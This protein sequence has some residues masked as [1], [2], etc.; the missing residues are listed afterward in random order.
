MSAQ[1]IVRPT[2]PLFIAKTSIESQ[3]SSGYSGTHSAVNEFVDNSIEAGATEVRV[4]YVPQREGR[5]LESHDIIVLDNGKGMDPEL[6]WQALAFGGGNRFD[7]R[8]IGRFGYGLPNAAISQGLHLDVY[9]W[10]SPNEVYKAELDVDRIKHGE[11]DGIQYPELEDVPDSIRRLLAR[12]IGTYPKGE[13][14]EEN[15]LLSGDW[16]DH[17]TLVVVTKCDRLSYKQT[18]PFV[19]HS[20]ELGRIYRYKLLNGVRIYVNNRLIDP[21]DPLYLNPSARHSGAAAW[22]D[23]IKVEIPLLDPTLEDEEGKKNLPTLPVVARFSLLPEAWMKDDMKVNRNQRHLFY[24]H[25]ISVLRADREMEMTLTKIIGLKE[26]DSDAWWGGEIHVPPGLD[27][28]FGISNN[29]QGIHPKAYVK[30]YLSRAL[31]PAISRLRQTVEQRRKEQREARQGGEPTFTERRAAEAE[32]LLGAAYTIPSDPQYQEQVEKS[33]RDF[34]K[35]HCRTGE[36]PEV[37]YERIKRST[38]L[39][40]FEHSPEGPFYRVDNFGRHVVTY[41]NT[42]HKFYDK[43]WLPLGNLVPAGTADNGGVGEGDPLD[44]DAGAANPQAA[45]AMLL[46]TIGRVEL[47]FRDRGE[48]AEELF[49]T[50]RSDW[51][52]ALRTFLN[53]LN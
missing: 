27:E 18:R 1:E 11:L 44:G 4:Y 31:K 6:L 9:T 26:K 36:T 50:L 24:H 38:H 3:R 40:E 39:L 5:K 8:G 17:G 28:A 7:R 14:Q 16:P 29:K 20:W 37:A 13:E 12:P 42:A 21:V 23:E 43:I 2:V 45:M 33:L 15:L 46:M 51:S 47:S 35:R 49:R 22:G 41:I 48:E 32:K 19:E 30:E 52:T 10:Q 34:A 25:G 53:N